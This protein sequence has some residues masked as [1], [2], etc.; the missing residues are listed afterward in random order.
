M[1]I[2]NWI[3]CCSDT[4]S[5]EDKIV[6]QTVALFDFHVPTKSLI[7]CWIGKDDDENKFKKYCSGPMLLYIL[8][9]C[10]PTGK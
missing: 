1:L 9:A 6:V 10:L 7:F 4:D 8:D 5:W 2:S 3:S